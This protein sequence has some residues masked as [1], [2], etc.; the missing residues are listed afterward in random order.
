MPRLAFLLLVAADF[1]GLRTVS[2]I[3]RTVYGLCTGNFLRMSLFLGLY[4]LFFCV[5]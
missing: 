2:F 4:E 5:L 3:R 1:P